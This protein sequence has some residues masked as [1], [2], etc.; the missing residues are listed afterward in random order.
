MDR[1]LIFPY[2]DMLLMMQSL[3]VI[4]IKM[5]IKNHFMLDKADIQ[6]NQVSIRLQFPAFPSIT[7]TCEKKNNKIIF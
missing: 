3:I 4:C 7:C 1:I 2:L 5:K 6:H